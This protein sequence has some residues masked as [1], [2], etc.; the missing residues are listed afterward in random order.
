M[1]TIF[2][3]FSITLTLLLPPLNVVW[4]YLVPFPPSSTVPLLTWYNCPLVE[5]VNPVNVVYSVILLNT[6][7]SI[8]PLFFKSINFFPGAPS[9]SKFITVPLWSALPFGLN[10]A[11]FVPSPKYEY[12]ELSKVIKNCILSSSSVAVDGAPV[13]SVVSVTVLDPKSPFVPFV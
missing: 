3:L 10:T 5:F 12:G 6:S 7:V 11:I 1:L 2:P 8:F 13:P 4:I 9:V